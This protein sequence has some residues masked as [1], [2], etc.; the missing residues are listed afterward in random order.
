MLS[1]IIPTRN[2]GK[3]LPALLKQVY[4]HVDEIVVSDGGSRDESLKEALRAGA[5]IALGCKGRGWQ[6]RRGAGWAKGD[7]LLFLHAD[8]K[9]GAGWREAVGAHMENHAD[10]AGYFQFRVAA[11]GWRPRL[12]ELFVRTRC[13]VLRLPYGD[14]G[15]LIS[16]T[17]YEQ[18]GG[19]ENWDLFED[20]A[21]TKALGKNLRPLTAKIYTYPGKYER[22]GYASRTLKNVALMRRFQG[23]ANPDEL[24]KE[25]YR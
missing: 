23:G 4:G 17:L 21:I 6:L 7:W 9:L 18:V 2:A 16:R 22:Q 14:Q 25:Y 10:T 11:K 1:L 20:V 5:R 19:F 24:A 8:V 3:V 13:K 15:L 12:M